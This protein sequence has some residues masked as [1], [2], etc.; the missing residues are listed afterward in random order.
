MSN[1]NDIIQAIHDSHLEIEIWKYL[2]GYM[3]TQ[4]LNTRD[5]LREREA[6]IRAISKINQ[7]KNEAI[8]ALCD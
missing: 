8:S 5:T 4:L 7:N 6:S 3:E 2:N 1:K